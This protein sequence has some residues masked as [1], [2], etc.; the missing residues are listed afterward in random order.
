MSRN[1]V[2][3]N[4]IKEKLDKVSRQ[5]GFIEEITTT[6]DEIITA[7]VTDKEIDISQL[8]NFVQLIEVHNSSLK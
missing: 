7:I 1:T 3:I 8:N 4:S 5:C 6:L 2:A